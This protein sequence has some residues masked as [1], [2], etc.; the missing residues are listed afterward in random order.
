MI[1]ITLRIGLAALVL[2]GSL[3]SAALAQG[4]FDPVI[5]VNRAAITAYELEQRERFLEILQRSSGMAQRAR[6]SLIEDRLKMAAADRASIKLSATQVTKAMEDFAGNANLGLDQLLAS[7]AQS[8]VDAQTYRDFIKVGVTWRELVRARFAARSAPSEAEIDRALASAGAQG[9]VKVLL[10]EIVLPAGSA[11]ELNRARQT[12]ERL[13]RITS[14]ADFSEQARRL[15]VA[16]SRVNGGRLEWA[17]LSDLPDGLR[18]IISGLR[19]GQITKP[20][21]VTNA[22]VLFQLRDVAETTAQSPEVAAIEYARLSGPAEAVQTAVQ[23][24]DTCDDFYGA[25]KA[26]PAL[27]FKIH[28]E[29]PD[30]ISQALS[31]RLMGLDKDEFDAVP[32]S[33]GDQAEIVMLCA[34]VYAALEDVSRGQVADNLRSARISSLADGFLAELRASADIVYH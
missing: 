4:L 10:T 5:S 6:D 26:D 16:Q 29:S 30:Q 32:T 21:E 31:L 7:L 8:G 34:R 28:S 1:K 17:N 2:I 19:P 12:A 18:P 20:L 9:G 14:T 13:G 25:V 22:I 33:E 27:S 15:S 23:M 3:N 11:E 24:A